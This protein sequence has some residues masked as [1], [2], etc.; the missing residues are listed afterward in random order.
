MKIKIISMLLTLSALAAACQSAPSMHGTT[1]E[2]AAA[3]EDFT[4]HT[5]AADVSLSQFRGKYVILFFGFTHCEDV[6]PVTLAT[7]REALSTLGT[8]AERFQV[9]F[10]S[11]DYPRDTPQ[12]ASEYAQQ[13]NPRFIGASGSKEEIDAAASRF[14]VSYEFL[15]ADSEGNYEVEH[16][17]SVFVLDSNSRLTLTWPYGLTSQELAQDMKNLLKRK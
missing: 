6:C 13:F 4:L 7:L 8:D 11:V 17:A 2:S 10:I 12:V 5:S 16:S 14:G 15:P 9:I 1:F 3:V